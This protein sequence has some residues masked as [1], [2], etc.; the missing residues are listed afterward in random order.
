MNKKLLF[1]GGES[2]SDKKKFQIYVLCLESLN[3]QKLD[4][5]NKICPALILTNIYESGL[6]ND[7]IHI[8][9]GFLVSTNKSN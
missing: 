2:N 6:D 5:V 7:K 9:G 4:I 3:W 1:F 8:M